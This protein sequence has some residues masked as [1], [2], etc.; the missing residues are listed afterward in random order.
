MS[1]KILRPR[2]PEALIPGQSLGDKKG[3]IAYT[4]PSPSDG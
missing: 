4:I 2:V 3:P 1:K